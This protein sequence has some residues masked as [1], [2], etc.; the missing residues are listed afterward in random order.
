MLV[1]ADVSRL[2]SGEA[3]DGMDDGDDPVHFFVLRVV[4]CVFLERPSG[5][6]VCVAV[7]LALFVDD[8][9]T[10]VIEA[11][12]PTGESCAWLSCFEEPMEWLMVA[13]DCEVVSIEELSEV[14]DG[15][16]DC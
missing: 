2:C 10:E 8:A 14:F 1:V 4:C 12:D 9:E 3:E 15:E 11:D 5:E 6:S 13:V 16:D 7:C